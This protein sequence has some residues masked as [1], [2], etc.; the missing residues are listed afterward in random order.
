MRAERVRRSAL[1]DLVKHDNVL[2][3]PVS[4]GKAH[5]AKCK[6]THPN[7]LTIGS[8][9]YCPQHALNAIDTEQRHLSGMWARA[10]DLLVDEN[11]P[12]AQYETN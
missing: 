4:V 2:T 1:R 12:D 8:V 6:E 10:W 9:D 3:I 11:E 5:C 7:L